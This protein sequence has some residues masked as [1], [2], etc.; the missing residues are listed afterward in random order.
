MTR[1]GSPGGSAASVGDSTTACGWRRR[2]RSSTQRPRRPRSAP[3]TSVPSSSVPGLFAACD[4]GGRD[5]QHALAAERLRE[6]ARPRRPAPSAASTRRQQDADHGAVAVRRGVE[7]VRPEEHGRLRRRTRARGSTRATPCV[8]R[9]PRPRSS[10]RRP[11]VATRSGRPGAAAAAIGLTVPRSGQV[12][13]TTCDVRLDEP[14]DRLAEVAHRLRRQ[15][16]VRHVVGPDRR[17]R[18]RRRAPSDRGVTCSARSAD[19]APTLANAAQVHAAVGLRR[20]RR[21][22]AGHRASPGP[23]RRRSRPRWSR[24]AGRC[25]SVGPGRPRPYQPVALGRVAL[26]PP[27]GAAGPA[28]LGGEHAVERAAQHGQPAAAVRRRRCQLAC[29]PRLAHAPTLRS[30]PDRL[31]RWTTSTPCST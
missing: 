10:G 30:G 25:P 31:A 12:P 9:P 29:R 19:C 6:R 1:P 7:P 22:P 21:T 14:P 13:T 8:R 17:S 16:R 24:R 26:E 11:A 23:S 28:C 20:P 3:A 15:H 27:D 5:G 4:R 18:P 2:C